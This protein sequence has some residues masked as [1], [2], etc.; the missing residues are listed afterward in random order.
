MSA[1]GIFPVGYS[2]GTLFVIHVI[3]REDSPTPV[4]G[5]TT[6]GVSWTQ[7]GSTRFLDIGTTGIALS[8]WYRFA[9]SGA[10]TAPAVT[11]PTPTT[12]AAIIAG[13]NGVDQTTPLDGVTPTGGTNAAATT[14]Q[15]GGGT[16]ITTATANAWVV[17]CVCTPDDNQLT[18][19]IDNGFAHNYFGTSY[20]SAALTDWSAGS[21][22]QQKA[23]PGNVTGPTW[24][25]DLNGADEWAWQMFVLR[26]AGGGPPAAIGEDPLVVGQ[27]AS[28]QRASNW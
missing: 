2:A 9:A 28:L 27:G 13:Y 19:L 12:L 21:S 6:S 8:N 15:P 16:G 18:Q 25:Q 11:C 5:V 4:H 3:S 17:N 7:I 26:P 1:T 22:W 23:T 14:L 20:Q 10:E 24:N